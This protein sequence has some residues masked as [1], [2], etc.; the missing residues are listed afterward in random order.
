MK[1]WIPIAAGVVLGGAGL[2]FV[3]H[4]ASAPASKATTQANFEVLDDENRRWGDRFPNIELQTHDGRTVKFY[5]D[6]IK[7]KVVALNFMY[8]GCLEF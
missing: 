6:L 4:L 5:D 1:S 2:V 8:C 3:N 7:G